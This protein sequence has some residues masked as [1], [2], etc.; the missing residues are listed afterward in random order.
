MCWFQF[1]S[2]GLEL[3]I[4]HLLDFITCLP[5]RHCHPSQVHICVFGTVMECRSRPRFHSCMSLTSLCKTRGVHWTRFLGQEPFP[6]RLLAKAGQWAGMGSVLLRRQSSSASHLQ[7]P[8]S[9]AV[10][11]GMSCKQ[12][13]RGAWTLCP[14]A[15]ATQLL[16]RW[17]WA[18]WAWKPIP[19]QPK[20]LPR[21]NTITFWKSRNLSLQLT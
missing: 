11:R 1:C 21:W 8:H 9:Q 5:S 10:A 6:E 16:S 15:S 19:S 20:A 13:G 18:L 14:I 17:T 7:R 2:L 4:L 12:M 3:P